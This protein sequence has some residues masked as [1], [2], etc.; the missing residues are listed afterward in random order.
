MSKLVT[1]KL[2][3]QFGGLVAVKSVDFEMEQGSIVGIIGPNGAGKTTFINVISGIYLPTSGSITFDGQDITT[4]PPY[5]RSKMGIGRTYQL[6]HPLE[7]LNV[8]ENIMTGCIFTQNAAVRQARHMAEDLCKLVGLERI[9]RAVSQ[10]T[11]LEVKKMELAHALGT[12]PRVLFLDEIMAGLN[13]DETNDMIKTVRA[14]AEDRNL[15]VGVVEHVMNVIKEI[16]HT[17]IVLENGQI[18]AAG[19]Y[20]EVSQN[21]QVIEA[22][23]GAEA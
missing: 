14:V 5:L 11:I 8:R 22:Y 23:L 10:L 17:V 20:D 19:P 9:D 16:T 1:R 2:T 21:P 12:N 18:I 3:K 7:D 4:T 6:I 13:V 15:A